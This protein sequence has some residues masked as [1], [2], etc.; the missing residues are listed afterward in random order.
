MC[1][2]RYGSGVGGQGVNYRTNGG[3]T[4]FIIYEKILLDVNFAMSQTFHQ[5]FSSTR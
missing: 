1:D 2:T 3:K 5:I 4:V